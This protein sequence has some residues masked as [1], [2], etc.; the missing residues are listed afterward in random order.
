MAFLYIMATYTVKS[1]D[2]L[3]KIGAQ[4]GVDYKSITGYR[5]GNPNLIYPGEVLSIPDKG[6]AGPAPAANLNQVQQNLN[7]VQNQTFQGYTAPDAPKVQTATEI[8]T[9]VKGSGLLPTGQAP[10]TPD[11]TKAYTDLLAEKGVDA[12]Q[13]SIIDL[14]AQQDT[15][16]AQLRT[17]VAAERDKPVATNVIEGRI[18]EQQ[19]QSQEQYEFVGRQLSRKTDELNSALTNVKTIMDLKQT[20]YSNA[21]AAYNKQFDQA[22]STFNLI[23]GIQQDQ[24]SAADRA[25]D[26]AR[27]NAQIYVNALKDGNIDLASMSPDQKAQLNKL[28]VQAGFPVGFFSSIKKDP[29]ADI[30]A[31]TSDNGQIQVL[32]RNTSGG[33]T[34]QTYG[35]K[36]VGTDATTKAEDKYLNE[37]LA[38]FKDADT[39]V[40][41]KSGIYN[42]D[43][44]KTLNQEEANY[45]LGRIR[46]LVKDPTIADSLFTRAWSVGGYSR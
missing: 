20:D 14:K 18:S 11:L 10:A 9:D 4:Y 46:A 1:G 7:Q 17:N 36:T 19:R 44:D 30:V 38:I 23:R 28:E 5:S 3:S 16:A 29:K 43:E 24:K 40:Q 35:T 6:G 41:K 2:T 26:N 12:I 34:L 27:A 33:M 13:K 39:Y 21:S 31:T 45:A 25:Q 8:L 15:L 22:I 42:P 32:M 37:A